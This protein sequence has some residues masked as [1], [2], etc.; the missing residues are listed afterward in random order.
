MSFPYW[1]H[2]PAGYSQRYVVYLPVEDLLLVMHHTEYMAMDYDY[3][4]VNGVVPV[5]LDFYDAGDNYNKIFNIK[6]N[7]G[8]N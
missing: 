6:E 4:K 7:N 3:W 8:K 2:H 5:W 1:F